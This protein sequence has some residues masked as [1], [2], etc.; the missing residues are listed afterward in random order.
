MVTSCYAW[1]KMKKMRN[2][3]INVFFR[4]LK[5]NLANFL[6]ILTRKSKIFFDS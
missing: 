5:K 1:Y 3:K 2:I 6:V 4:M